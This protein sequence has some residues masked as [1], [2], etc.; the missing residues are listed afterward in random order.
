[1]LIDYT[2]KSKGGLGYGKPVGKP[3]LE[4]QLQLSGKQAI[5]NVIGKKGA[6]NGYGMGNAN[7]YGR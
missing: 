1:V 4:Q 2:A 6:A 5:S 3:G 7:G